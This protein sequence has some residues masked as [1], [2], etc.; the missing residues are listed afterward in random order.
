[1]S[2]DGARATTRSL[3]LAVRAPAKINLGLFVGPPRADGRHELA[4]VMQSISLAD[5]LTLREMRDGSGGDRV[6]CPGVAGPPERNL[7][8]SALAAFRVASGWRAPAL[9]LTIDKHVPVAAGLGGGSGDAAA[10]L[11]L[12]AAAAGL[13]DEQLLLELA[14]ELGADVPAQVRPGRWLAGGAG[15]RLHALPQPRTPFGVL[16]L[17]AAA[18]LST[19]AV[20]TQADRIRAP[21]S[22]AELNERHDALARELAAGAPLPAAELLHNDLQDAARALCPEIDAALAQARSA[23]ADAALVS[24]SGPTVLGLFA[25]TDGYERAR[26][27]ADGLRAERQAAG[28]PEPLAA[29][30][31]DERF[32][33]VEDASRRVR[34]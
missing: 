17:P 13:G 6:V 29:A 23:G 11:R 21:R 2:E 33:T 4:S 19:A 26:A 9:E 5:T 25:G 12:L 18:A 7:A 16:V 22:A 32:A 28:V 27:A 24:G 1:M 20:Y 14:C 34:A 3:P 8:A 15:E 31:V 10:T 30:P